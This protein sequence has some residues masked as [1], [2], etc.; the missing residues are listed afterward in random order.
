MSMCILETIKDKHSFFLNKHKQV[1]D[2]IARICQGK[3]I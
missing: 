1:T 3:V 2:R